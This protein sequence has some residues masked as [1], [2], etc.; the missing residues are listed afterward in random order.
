MTSAQD[1][2]V[3]GLDEAL[4]LVCLAAEVAPDRFDGFAGR[5]LTRLA[6]ERPLR[7]PEL[8]PAIT[9]IRALPSPR[10]REALRALL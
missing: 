10:A 5:W 4:D 1:M 6:A 2:G 7:I 9:A 8:D 3:V